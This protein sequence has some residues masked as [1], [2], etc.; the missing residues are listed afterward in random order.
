MS[1]EVAIVATSEARFGQVVNLPTIGDVQVGSDGTV[2]VPE[3]VAELLVSNSPSWRYLEEKEEEGE[4]E[5]VD[6][7][8]EEDD[9][10]DE[11]LTEDNDQDDDGES[12]D[13]FV[14]TPESKEKMMTRLSRASAAKITEFMRSEGYEIEDNQFTKK[15]LIETLIAD[16]GELSKKSRL[17]LDEMK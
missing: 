16:Y 14:L 10:D 13:K 9:S 1:K 15:Q 7:D 17:K 8:Q 12:S 3:E 11:N 6:K 5:K 2:M 4:E